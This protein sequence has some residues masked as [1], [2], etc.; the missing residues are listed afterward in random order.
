MP[1]HTTSNMDTKQIKKLEEELNKEYKDVGII[2]IETVHREVIDIRTIEYIRHIMNGIKPLDIDKPIIVSK[3]YCGN[4]ILIDGYHRLKHKIVDGVQEIDAIVLDEY[5]LKRTA[6]YLLEFFKGLV[7]KTV[8][9]KNDYDFFVDEKQY[10]IAP[11]RGCGGCEN[12]WAYINVSYELLN[13]SIS[14][15]SVE[16]RNKDGD[17]YD[18]FVN[19]SFIAAIDTGWGNGYYGGDFEI[20]LIN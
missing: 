18:M 20:D 4:F 12:G 7:G 15:T 13:K 17:K 2:S 5:S 8:T 19:G 6:G 1:Q 14:V 10:S 9:F 3:H 11:N 16:A